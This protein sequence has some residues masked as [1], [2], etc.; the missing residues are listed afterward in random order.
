MSWKDRVANLIYN[1]IVSIVDKDTD[2]SEVQTE[3]NNQIKEQVSNLLKKDGT[4]VFVDPKSGDIVIDNDTLD[5]IIFIK[6]NT[7][8]IIRSFGNTTDNATFN[9]SLITTI[10]DIV[11]DHIS[12]IIEGKHFSIQKRRLNQLNEISPVISEVIRVNEVV[13]N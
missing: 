5:L 11:Y 9:I 12:N 13:I 8:R 1:T 7:Q 3:L 4:N 10:K 2:E 6:P